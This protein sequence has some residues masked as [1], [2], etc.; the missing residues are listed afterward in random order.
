MSDEPDDER[1]REYRVTPRYLAGSS[2]IGDPGFEPVAHWPHHHSD[3]GPCQ[4]MFTSPDHRI[5]IGWFGDDVDLWKITAAED[6]V[7]PPLWQATFNHNFPPQ[8]VAG[9]TTA[10]VRDWDPESER[11]LARPSMYWADSVQPLLD[12][13][14]V[15]EAP[16]E[17]CTVP[18]LAPDDH[19][20]ALF[21]AAVGTPWPPE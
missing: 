16:A 1:W 19:A 10:L 20:G 12:A 11:F 7:S 18:I 17:R 9:L 21:T 6:A 8:V 14:W 4:L 2:G 15:Q 13:G 3:D 5:K